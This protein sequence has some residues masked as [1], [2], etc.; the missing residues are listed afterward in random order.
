M[1]QRILLGAGSNLVIELQM[2]F[3]LE[4][5]AKALARWQLLDA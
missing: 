1:M 2:T 4:R 3:V 5:L